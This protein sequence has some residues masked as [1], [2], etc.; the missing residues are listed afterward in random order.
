VGARRGQ[1]SGE[2]SSKPLTSATQKPERQ[3]RLIIRN[4]DESTEG[5]DLFQIPIADLN[6]AGHFPGPVL[7]II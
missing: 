7:A 5:A 3:H 2:R 6:V 4:A 1:S